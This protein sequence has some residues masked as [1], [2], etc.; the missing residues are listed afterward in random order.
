MVQ[1]KLPRRISG[2]W[3]GGIAMIF[4]YLPINWLDIIPDVAV[5]NAGSVIGGFGPNFQADFRDNPFSPQ[6]GWYAGCILV[7]LR[8]VC[9]K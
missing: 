3:F 4:K 8:Q 6:N 9:R 7:C 1:S 2:N 5:G